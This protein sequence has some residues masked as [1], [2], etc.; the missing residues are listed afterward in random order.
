MD[1]LQVAPRSGL[2]TGPFSHTRYVIKRPWFSFLGRKLYVYAP[3]G[4]LALFVR[5]K[6]FTLKDE[7]LVCADESEQR[8]L[9]RLKARQAIAIDVV[10]D[11][12][13]LASDR[14]LGA[15]RNKGFKSIVR[16]TWELLDN[17]D[18]PVGTFVEDSNALLRRFLPILTGHWHAELGGAKVAQLDQVF[19]FFSK[20]FVLDLTGAAGKA[21]PRF[22][23]G[24]ALLALMREMAREARD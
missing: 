13:D 12:V 21:D 5:H 24:C 3:D 23:L 10:T 19:R 8:P 17:Q 22:L 14:H 16:D 6:L 18:A 2:A 20:E 11:V 4:S 1:A 7:W 15:V 9:L